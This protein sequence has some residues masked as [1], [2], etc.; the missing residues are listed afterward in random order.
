[1][2]VC[3]LSVTSNCHGFIPGHDV[4]LLNVRQSTSSIQKQPLLHMAPPSPGA[5]SGSFFNPVPENNDN[6][7]KSDETPSPSPSSDKSDDF[8]VEMTELLR[9]RRKPSKASRPS[10]INGVPTAKASGMLFYLQEAYR[11]WVKTICVFS[12]TFVPIPVGFHSPYH[13]LCSFLCLFVCS[14]S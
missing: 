12:Y 14:F 5:P 9:Q 2:I 7:E 8:D 1:M 4:S 11:A 10:T 6:D 3:L 13:A